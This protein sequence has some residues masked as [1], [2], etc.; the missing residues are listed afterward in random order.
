MSST[1]DVR[2]IVLYLIIFNAHTHIMPRQ[3]LLGSVVDFREDPCTSGTVAEE[4]DGDSASSTCRRT[5]SPCLLQQ[6]STLFR[7]GDNETSFEDDDAIEEDPITLKYDTYLRT[8][9][10][11]A[12]A[13][14]AVAAS[15]RQKLL[16]RRRRRISCY[17]SPWYH[18]T[19]ASGRST[20]TMRRGCWP[21]ASMTG[22][23]TVDA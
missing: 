17:V 1:L 13:A 8:R 16:R 5:S 14:A 20:Y 12:A 15:L 19:T 6:L 10:K 21:T 7:L 2:T 4:E 22:A 3:Q 11:A 23:L 9:G 18:S